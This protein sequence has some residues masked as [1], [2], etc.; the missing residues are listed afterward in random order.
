MGGPTYRFYLQPKFSISG[1]VMGG[2]ADGNF[3][4][5]TNGFGAK[6]LGL[7]PDGGTFAISASLPVE[8]NLTPAIGLRLAPEYFATGFGSTLQNSVG[9]TGSI[10]VRF[11]KQ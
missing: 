1:R 7:Y 4:S 9:F 3:S 5:D 11:G 2:F 8:Y 10:V 6:A